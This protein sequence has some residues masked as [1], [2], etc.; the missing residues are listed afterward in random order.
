[1]H[2]LQPVI[3]TGAL[4]LL[5]CLLGF[6]SV[7]RQGAAGLIGEELVALFHVTAPG[8]TQPDHQ[9]AERDQ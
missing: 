5:P 4:A 1:M 9:Q 3:D 8:P 2:A 6:G 7:A